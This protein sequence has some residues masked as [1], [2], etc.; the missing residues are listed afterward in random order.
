MLLTFVSDPLRWSVGDPH[1]DGGKASFELAFGPGTPAHRFPLGMIFWTCRC[2]GRS[3]L[4]T[5][6]IIG[7]PMG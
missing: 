6:Q 7:T 2:R 4:V 3:R 1:T 5:G